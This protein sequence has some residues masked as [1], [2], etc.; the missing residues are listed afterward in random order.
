M[1]RACSQAGPLAANRK[2]QPPRVTVR[3]RLADPEAGQREHLRQVAVG[4][5]TGI[6]VKGDLLRH[7][8][9]DLGEQ[10]IS[11]GRRRACRALWTAPGRRAGG[12]RRPRASRWCGPGSRRLGPDEADRADV[13]EPAVGQPAVLDTQFRLTEN[14]PATCGGEQHLG[15]H[16]G[17]GTVP[18]SI[19]SVLSRAG[20]PGRARLSLERGIFA[21]AMSPWLPRARRHQCES[22][23]P[24]KGES[25]P[26]ERL[27]CMRWRGLEPPRPNRVTRPST[28]RVY[29]FRHQR[30]CDDAV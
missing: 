26:S 25:R 9:G 14:R 1:C 18:A 28:L 22:W 2:A 5:V 11:F 12:W 13:A 3:Q 8:V 17:L 6:E 15:G 19:P 23:R 27:S 20:T 4:G 30:A 24:A 16:R 29:Q 10:A 7:Q 21:A